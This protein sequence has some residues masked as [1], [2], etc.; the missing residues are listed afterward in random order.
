MAETK[1]P[2][3]N[4]DAKVVAALRLSGDLLRAEFPFAVATPAAVFSRGDMLWLIFDSAAKIDVD[5]LA[6][7]PSHAIR[8]AVLQHGADGEAI[9]RIKL[10]RPRLVSLRS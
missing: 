4:P 7:D 9:V 6:D 5:A 10:E 1:Q 8:S 3:P 2:A